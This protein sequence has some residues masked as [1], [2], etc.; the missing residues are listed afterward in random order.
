[1]GLAEDNVVARNENVD[2]EKGAMLVS[3][4]KPWE[5]ILGFLEGEDKVFLLGCRG[6]AEACQTGGEVQVQE[7][8][9]KLGEVGKKVT[10]STVID[11]LCDKALVRMRLVPYEADIL[12]ADSMLVM[13]CGIGV[14]S[15][16]SVV[17]VV[18]HPACNTINMGGARGEWRGSERCRECGECMLDLTGGIC[19]LTACTKSLLN[20][21]CGGTKDGR[22]EVE[23][24]VRPCGW[25]LIYE[26][27][28]TTG[29]LDKMKAGVAIKD[30]S[31]MQP[32]K[33]VR[34]TAVWALEQ[35]E[36]KEV[37]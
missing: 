27:L 15:V 2:E 9:Q 30:Y 31:K 36:K 25:H 7:M 29:Q 37:A 19:P 4:L 24:E 8:K 35:A 20:G 6:C 17:D 21:P 14:Q 26:R 3:E 5:E 28:K 10:G 33:E 34:S 22:C 1:M 13:T 32:P 23:P 18:T 16:S 11:F 12:A